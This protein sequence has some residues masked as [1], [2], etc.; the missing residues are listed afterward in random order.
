MK[1]KVL[2]ENRYLGTLPDVHRHA[3]SERRPWHDVD[4]FSVDTGHR[5]QGYQEIERLS[6][7]KVSWA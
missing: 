3:S 1:I 7:F 6:L 4:R 2:A 5:R